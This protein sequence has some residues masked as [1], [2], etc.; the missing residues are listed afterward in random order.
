MKYFYLLLIIEFIGACSHP[1]I[2]SNIVIYTP[3]SEID[4][5]EKENKIEI[6]E[7]FN[8][9][10]NLKQLTGE[11]AEDELIILGYNIL[12][13]TPKY[14]GPDSDNKYAGNHL[15]CTNCHL[16]VG[17]KPYGA[18]W[19][20]VTKRFPQFKGR[21]NDTI[22]I[23]QRIN[24]CMMRSMNGKP[25]PNNS[26]EM[27][28]MV[29]YMKWLSKDTEQGN[30]IKGKGFLKPEI[31]DRAVDLVAGKTIFENKCASCHNVTGLGA[32]N[33]DLGKYTYP[34]LWGDDSYNNGAG[35]TRVLTAMQFIKGNMPLGA[36]Y[37]NPILTDEEAYD[38][39]GYINSKQRPIK[40][41]L[42]K[43]FPDLK[44]KPVSSPYPPYADSFS[45]KKHQFGPFSEMIDYYQ[46]T[47]NIK[48]TK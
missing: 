24:G 8:N 32:F 10:F 7:V 2:D 12:K 48:K 37:N 39:A 11:T 34:P 20:G 35:M 21:E 5:V 46:S 27:N 16:N 19:I 18:P 30:K 45:Q 36:T 22:T 15:A 44:L 47:Y 26:K 9:D 23:Q 33:K 17:T 14:L 41:N 43:D 28:A 1:D 4:K 3:Q 29:A 40:D 25:L 42:D 31:P 6:D 38:V 13:N